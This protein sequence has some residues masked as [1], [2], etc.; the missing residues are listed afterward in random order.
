MSQRPTLYLHIG[1]SK[2]ATSTLQVF[3]KD[4]MPLFERAGILVPETGRGGA[5]SERP[6][7]H[8][9]F[10][11]SV[12][13]PEHRPPGHVVP[14]VTDLLSSLTDEIRSKDQRFN[15]LIS[16]EAFFSPYCDPS[17]LEPLLKTAL[18]KVVVYLRR[19]D[20]WLEAN[21]ATNIMM[22]YPGATSMSEFLKWSTPWMDYYNVLERWSAVFGVENVIVRRFERQHMV[23]RDALSDFLTTLNLNHTAMPVSEAA[24]FNTRLAAL[25][26]MLVKKMKSLLT[27]EQHRN[28]VRLIVQ[29]E[30]MGKLNYQPGHFL[31]IAQRDKLLGEAASANAEV[32]DR[33]SVGTPSEPLFSPPEEGY[34]FFD[35]GLVSEMELTL[36]ATKLLLMGESQSAENLKHHTFIE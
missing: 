3:L 9:I 18:V 32:A 2:T 1:T 7:S 14:T 34:N 5:F 27:T 16:S 29:G 30:S 26:L 17:L 4:Q 10:A 35:E 36:L 15:Y 8:H 6:V 11:W 19:Q 28:L 20:Q 31:T 12:T 24:I 22:P 13:S 23:S 33:Y 25:P 21:Y